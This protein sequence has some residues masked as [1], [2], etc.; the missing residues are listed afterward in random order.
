MVEDEGT[1]A[2]VIIMNTY[3]VLYFLG[4][5]FR[6]RVKAIQPFGEEGRSQAMYVNRGY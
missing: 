3:I 5:S 6:K 1:P 4:L 2:E